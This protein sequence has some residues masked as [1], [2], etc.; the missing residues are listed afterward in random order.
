MKLND[1][2]NEKRSLISKIMKI[3]NDT[4]LNVYIIKAA[5]TLLVIY[6]VDGRIITKCSCH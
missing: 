1:N 3:M 2:E 6:K 5:S 4:E